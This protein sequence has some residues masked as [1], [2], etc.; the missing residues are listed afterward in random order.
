MKIPKFETLEI[1]I[2]ENPE[3]DALYC[4]KDER[5][6]V[7]GERVVGNSWKSRVVAVSGEVEEMESE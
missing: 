3:I 6:E 5:D 2:F 1:Q 4:C 7:F